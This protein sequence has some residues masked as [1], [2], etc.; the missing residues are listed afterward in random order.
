M[1]IEITLR[2]STPG[3][4]IHEAEVITLDKPHDQLEA[5]GLSLDQA[6]DLLGTIQA[7]I[8]TA[9]AAAFSAERTKCTCCRRRLRKKGKFAI[10]FR[11]PFGDV[12]LESSRF[13]RCACS[14][15]KAGTY[16]PMRRGFLYLVA[17]M[18]WATRKVLAWRLSNT[19]E[20]GFCIRGGPTILT[21]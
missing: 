14:P 3:G 5:I 17:V 9:Q 21:S 2:V 16:I 7:S 13:Y 12:P 19:M 15:D 11:T 1:K 10:A 4:G 18:D 20:V 8:V 6:K